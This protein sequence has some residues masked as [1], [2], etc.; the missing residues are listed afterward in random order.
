MLSFDTRRILFSTLVVTRHERIRFEPAAVQLLFKSGYQA[1]TA[2]GAKRRAD[3]SNTARQRDSVAEQPVVRSGPG[4]LQMCRLGPRAIRLA[5]KH[6]GKALAAV[7]VVRVAIHLQT[8]HAPPHRVLCSDNQH[9]PVDRNAGPEP[10]VLVRALSGSRG[11]IRASISSA[12]LRAC[13]CLD[14]G[15]FFRPVN[16]LAARSA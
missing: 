16:Q 4:W 6:V 3:E 13:S 2:R 10:I 7:R 9:I 15:R 11:Q 8:G 12:R 1:G 5:L 14:L